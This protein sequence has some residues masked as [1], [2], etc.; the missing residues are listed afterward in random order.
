MQ[1]DEKKQPPQADD[2]DKQKKQPQPDDGL[3]DE[4]KVYALAQL[5][6]EIRRIKQQNVMQQD[7]LDLLNARVERLEGKSAMPPVGSA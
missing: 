4:L 1:D 5:V 7:L 3:P 2:T 6:R